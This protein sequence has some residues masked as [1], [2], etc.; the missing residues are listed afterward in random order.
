MEAWVGHP[1]T[2]AFA[3][4]PG[5]KDGL[6]AEHADTVVTRMAEPAARMLGMYGDF[7]ALV[8][9]PAIKRWAKQKHQVDDKTWPKISQKPLKLAGFKK[10][11]TLFEMQLDT[12]AL[13]STS[14]TI[15]KMVESMLPPADAKQISHIAVVVQPDGDFTYVMTGD[16]PKEMARVMAEHRKS[17]PGAPFARPAHADK[18]M[19]AGFLTLAYVARKVERSTKRLEIGRALGGTPNHGESPIAFATSAASGSARFDIE[20]PAAVFSDVSAAAISAAP[21]LKGVLQSSTE[22][23][24]QSGPVGIARQP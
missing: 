17:E 9:D 14:D 4:S 16:D 18:I 20:V 8:G 22:Q 21:V 5:Q 11:A 15:G 19:A 3:L 7:F 6:A 12:K 13:A 10:P 23:P 1:E 24:A 2:F